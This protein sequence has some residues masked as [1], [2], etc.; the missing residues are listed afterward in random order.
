VNSED[1]SVYVICTGGGGEDKKCSDQYYV[2]MSVGDHLNYLGVAFGV[3]EVEG[4]LQ[5]VVM[6][7]GVEVG[8]EGKVEGVRVGGGGGGSGGEVRAVG[9]IRRG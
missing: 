9:R 7:R 6:L 3:E 2:D 8:G 4:L 1:E 5:E